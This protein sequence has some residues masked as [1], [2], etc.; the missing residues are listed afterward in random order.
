MQHI[1]SKTTILEIRKMK[2]IENEC[3]LINNHVFQPL[4]LW[5]DPVFF[6]GPVFAGVSCAHLGDFST[7]DRSIKFLFICNSLHSSMKK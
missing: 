7:M 1:H 3:G 2:E 5:I 4:G 6:I